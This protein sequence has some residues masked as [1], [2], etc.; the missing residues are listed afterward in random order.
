MSLEIG[1][2]RLLSLSA[3]I[4]TEKGLIANQKKADSSRAERTHFLA[5]N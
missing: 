1:S 2:T 5:K 3:E 4:N